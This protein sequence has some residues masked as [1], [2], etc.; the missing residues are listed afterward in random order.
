M[1]QCAVSPNDHRIIADRATPDERVRGC[2]AHSS[3]ERAGLYAECF[4]GVKSA[5]GF[6]VLITRVQTA[7]EDMR[8]K[9]K[10]VSNI[11]AG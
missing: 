2:H 1:H 4:L 5:P 9:G 3:K 8:E 6:E 11:G 7:K 10:P